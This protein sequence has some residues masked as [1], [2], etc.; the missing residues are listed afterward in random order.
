MLYILR[1]LDI[2]NNYNYI[3]LGF[4][5]N[6]ELQAAKEIIDNFNSEW[7]ESQDENESRFTGSYEDDLR[8]ELKKYQL[9]E[10]TVFVETL[11]IK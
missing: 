4:D 5:T 11:L 8:N 7:D 2:E 6:E 3:N 1:V 9:N 10:K